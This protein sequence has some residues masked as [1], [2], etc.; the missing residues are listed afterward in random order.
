MY[1]EFFN[2]KDHPFRLT[3][4]ADYLYLSQAH[5]RAKACMEQACSQRDAL[6]VITGEVGCGKST[7]V[8]RV[9]SEMSS[10]VAVARLTQTNLDSEEFLQSV[11]SQYGFQPFERNRSKL[12][13][14]LDNFLF[15]QNVR[16]RSV[17]LIIEEAQNLSSSVLDVVCELAD[18]EEDTEKLISIILV[19]QPVLAER[20]AT[21]NLKTLSARVSCQAHLDP[22]SQSE[23]ILLIRHRLKLAGSQES[24]FDD[25]TYPDIFGFTGG[26]PRLIINLCD[27]AMTAAYVEDS[28]RI[29]KE[30]LHTAISELELKVVAEADPDL[31]VEDVADSEDGVL[32]E[33][34]RAVSLTLSERGEHLEDFVIND[35]RVMIGR[36][37]DND[38]TIVSEFISRHHAQ[39]VMDYDGQYWVKDLNSTNGMYVN[40]HKAKRLPLKDGDRI[41]MG[42]H[43]IVFYDSESA[44]DEK[45]STSEISQWRETAVFNKSQSDDDETGPH[46]IIKASNDE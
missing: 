24:P 1:E 46:N 34:A 13:S 20:L 44:K 39:I 2:L 26:V 30:I 19:G 45:D 3:P 33:G 43:E 12:M 8:N 16:E 31:V 38:V 21:K 15:A 36:D 35:T 41:A 9:M 25:D 23:T 22:L 14:L 17:V 42:Y 7:L 37:S 6:A 32:P 27:T 10:E 4:D 11:L 18:L 29:N 5:A 28:P 40:G